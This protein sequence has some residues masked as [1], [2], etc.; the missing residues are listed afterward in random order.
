MDDPTFEIHTASGE[1]L[2]AMLEE[3]SDNHI[4]VV[5][6]FLS[7]GELLRHILQDHAKPLM[8]NLQ[9]SLLSEDIVGP[10][11][12][13]MR[14]IMNNLVS[15]HLQYNVSMREIEDQL[16]FLGYR[17]AAKK[18][19]DIINANNAQEFTRIP[20]VGK[21]IPQLIGGGL[22]ETKLVDKRF[23]RWIKPFPTLHQAVLRELTKGPS[24]GDNNLLRNYRTVVGATSCISEGNYQNRE[25]ITPPQTVIT[26]ETGRAFLRLGLVHPEV[27][28]TTSGHLL[29]RTG[30]SRLIERATI[31]E[32]TNRPR[33]MR[34]PFGGRGC[35][36]NRGDVIRSPPLSQNPRKSFIDPTA[37]HPTTAQQSAPSMMFNN[38]APILQSQQQTRRSNNVCPYNFNSLPANEQTGLSSGR[39]GTADPGEGH[40][41]WFKAWEK[42]FS[43]RQNRMRSRRGEK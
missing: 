13:C 5:T 2:T 36:Q 19:V 40:L 32:R 14:E 12:W 38:N 31:V 16:N 1:F 35:V 26:P 29:P 28:L 43:E 42:D 7:A 23:D 11:R 9:V 25:Y 33:Y 6:I 22:T 20:W 21:G 24:T 17:R 41:R 4:G 15:L 27:E 30:N 8:D 3:L 18:Q 39:R 34:N 10:D 37:N